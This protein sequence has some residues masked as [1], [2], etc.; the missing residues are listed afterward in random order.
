MGLPT[1]KT[2]GKPP[3]GKQSIL[4]YGPAKIG[5]STLCSYFPDTLFLATEPGLEFLSV[6]EQPVHNWMDFLT[7]C[8][9]LAAGEHGFKTVVID[10]VDMLV[11]YCTEYICKR[12]RI[13]HPSDYEYGKGWSMVTME[14]RTKLTKLANMGL[15]IV[16]V[17]HMKMEEIKTK[18]KSFN[19]QTISVTGE[20]RKALL[21]MPNFVLYM[22]AEEVEG[23]EVGV[24]RTKPSIYWEGGDKSNL[25]PTEVQFPL[26]KPKVAYDIIYKALQQGE[27]AN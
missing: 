19:K 18:S 10:T 26:A 3:L 1:T 7:A 8:K 23:K 6:Y 16:M 15:G 14:L 27:T 9:D 5:K 21:A 13:N 4:L 2:S 12:E 11:L 22:N 20:N 17:S 25:L 24:I